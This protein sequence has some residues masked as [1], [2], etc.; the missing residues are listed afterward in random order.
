MNEKT[1]SFGSS[2]RLTARARAAMVSAACGDALG[3]PIEPRGQR[4]GGTAGLR[5]SLSFID[6]TRREGGGYAPYQRSIPA[7]AYSDDTQL[8]IATA[9]SLTCGNGW[10]D[11]LIGFELPAWTLYELGGG[12][13]IKRAAQ[14]WS[15]GHA[16]WESTKA[17]DRQRYFDAGANGVAMRILP[18]AIFGAREHEFETTA[19]RIVADGVATHGHPRALVGALAAG[20]AMW[21]ALRWTG[22]VNYGDL[23]EGCLAERRNWG[24][25]PSGLAGEWRKAAEA[26]LNASYEDVWEQTCEEMQGLLITSRQA[27]GRGS[28]AR[29]EEVLDELGAYGKEGGSGTRTAAVAIYLASRY[30]AQPAAGLLA[31]AFARK[32]DTDTIACLVG[33][34]LGAFSG[35][36]SADGL[37]DALMDA[38]YIRKLATAVADHE[39]DLEVFPRWTW[40]TKV[41]ILRDLAERR[42]G[43]TLTLPLF[44]TSKLMNVQQPET[45]SANKVQ[46]W[47]LSTEIGQTLAVTQIS[48]SQRRNSDRGTRTRDGHDSG[49]LT[50]DPPGRA[51]P[52]ADA[53]AW[54]FVFVKNLTVALELYNGILGI[55]IRRSRDRSIVLDGHLVLEESESVERPA[56]EPFKARGVIGIFVAQDNLR[57]THDRAIAAGYQT[58]PIGK[59]RNGSRFRLHDQDGHVVEIFTSTIS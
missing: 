13:A 45:K 47:W 44:G 55:P 29:D 11:Q 20:F 48:K 53:S 14:R 6:W 50:I 46:I 18:H 54:N 31:S 59:G 10:R 38:P 24:R 39:T 52:R 34:M 36:D 28:L 3:W 7:G 35:D 17:S 43:E 25:L 33:G 16:P 30:V 19:E 41:E 40:R 9:R 56:S 57:S 4:V 27:I 51:D 8:M 5:P 49:Q 37:A 15:K 32:A 23:I 2:A 58:S 42:S 21:S 12:G 26:T 1:G 22:K